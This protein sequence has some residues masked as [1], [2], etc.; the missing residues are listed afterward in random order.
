MRQPS[1]G[2][3]SANTSTLPYP[4]LLYP[5]L[6]YPT[7]PGHLRARTA[8]WRPERKHIGHPFLRYSESDLAEEVAR[9]QTVDLAPC[10]LQSVT[11]PLRPLISRPG[12]DG[13]S[14]ALMQMCWV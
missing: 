1:R 13:R 3:P 7:L 11:D 12:T 5:T 8:V 10:Q 9:V 2:A 6:P 14:R 4:T